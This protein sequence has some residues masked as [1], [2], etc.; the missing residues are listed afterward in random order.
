MAKSNALKITAKP[1]VQEMIVTRVVDA[2]RDLVF[3]AYIDPIMIPEWWGPARLATTV[4]KMDARPGGLW[5]VV[6][7]D[8]DGKV[9][10]FH[11]VYHAVEPSEQL[12]STFEFEDKPGHV[13][14]DIATFED[15][16][17]KTKLTQKTVFQTVADR[18]EM[19]KGDMESGMVEAYERLDALL[20]KELVNG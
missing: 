9:Y 11:G 3:K 13:A 14:L 2:P 16:N 4:E 18:D 6:Q 20:A 10:S 17:G 12:V 15:L 1:G 5:K 8:T 19:M 7:R